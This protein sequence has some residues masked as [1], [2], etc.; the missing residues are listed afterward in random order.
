M[1]SATALRRMSPV[2]MWGSP[3]SSMILLGLR[4]LARAGGPQQDDVHVPALSPFLV[5]LEE[6]VVVTHLQLAL[7]LRHGLE[8]DAHHDE[9]RRAAELLQQR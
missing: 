9:D 5:L 3:Y 6:A 4:A 2:E 1:P 8:R 7:E